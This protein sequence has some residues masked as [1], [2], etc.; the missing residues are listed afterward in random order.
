[1]LSS[2][3]ARAIRG[4]VAALIAT[5]VAVVAH[6]VADGHLVS[7]MTMLVVLILAAPVCVFLAGK[8]LSWV[9][10][11][12]AVSLSQLAFHGL[13]SIGLG[14]IAMPVGHLSPGHVHG[15]VLPASG[16]SSTA[17]VMNGDP[18]MWIAHVLAMI[19]TVALLGCGEQIVRALLELTGWRLVAR[20]LRSAP[21]R[22]PRRI[23]VAVPWRFPAPRLVTRRA[24]GMRGPPVAA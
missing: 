22:S 20:M 17:H 13:L 3:A 10:L 9:R 21:L 18:R 14:G 16:G 1:M 4:T 7:P 15:V 12:L 19:V 2:R 11:T 5:F 24:W 8:K 6:S 23:V